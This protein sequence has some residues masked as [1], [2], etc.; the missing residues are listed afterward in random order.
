M[1]VVAVV[2]GVV[3]LY[4]DLWHSQVPGNHFQAFGQPFGPQHTAHAVIG[5]ILLIVA[6]WLWMRAGKMATKTSA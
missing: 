5:L 1:K 2:V 4:L 3:G 6:A